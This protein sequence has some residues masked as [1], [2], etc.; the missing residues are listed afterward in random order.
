MERAIYGGCLLG[1]TE[2]HRIGHSDVDLRW[3]GAGSDEGGRVRS[4]SGREVAEGG[5]SGL[6]E[7]HRGGLR[8]EM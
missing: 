5:G 1:L 8:V 6:I 7:T 3:I 2:D 4:R